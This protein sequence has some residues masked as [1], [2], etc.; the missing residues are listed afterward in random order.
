L[1]LGLAASL[2]VKRRTRIISALVLFLLALTF[3]AVVWLSPNTRARKA[4]ERLRQTLRA[5]GFKLD[6]SEFD[7]SCSDAQR[8]QAILLV[9]AGHVC[10]DLWPARELDLARPIATNVAALLHTQPRLTTELSDD[11]WPALENAFAQPQVALA[12][13]RACAVLQ[14]GPIRFDPV[15]GPAGDLTV[16]YLVDVRSLTAALAARTVCE[17]HA[18]EHR[19]AF[20]NLLALTRLATQWDIEPIESAH[21]MRFFI[22]GIAE[23]TLWEALPARQLKE[24]ELRVLQDEWEKPQFFKNLPSAIAMTRANVLAYCSYESRQPAR[25]PVPMRQVASELLTDPGQAWTDLTSGISDS[26]YRRHGVYVDEKAVL[27]YFR[28]RELET[29]QAIKARAW[30]EMRRLPGVTNAPAFQGA[31][32]STITTRLNARPS[33]LVVLR[34]GYGLMRRAAEAEAMRRLAVTALALERYRLRTGDYPKSLDALAPE[35]VK[36]TPIDFMDAKPLRYRFNGTNPFTLYSIGSDCV[37]DGGQ[38]M[39]SESQSL[40]F[41]RSFARREGP[42]LVW[43]RPATPTRSW[44]I[45]GK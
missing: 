1:D 18:G 21:F 7:I 37:D 14:T 8:E 30:S 22:V 4:A 38:M 40:G 36:T 31:P 45:D 19:R 3:L 17:L 44:P 28:D 26:R 13:D 9:A 32:R 42:D 16:T 10:R 35:F 39:R 12:L 23:R 43:P 33:G 11:L 29:A 15:P 6:V 2:P 20:T 25:N 41:S 27:L 34:Q 24:S 5:Q